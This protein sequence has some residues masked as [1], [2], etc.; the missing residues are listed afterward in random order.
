VLFNK[1]II[2]RQRLEEIV[3]GKFMYMYVL[4]MD[5][6]KDFMSCEASTA[7]SYD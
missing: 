3:D 7:S 5:Y 6:F 1:V 4:N 2:Q